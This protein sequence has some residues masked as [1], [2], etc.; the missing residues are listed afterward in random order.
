MIQPKPDPRVDAL[1][2]AHLR[3]V[4][5]IVCRYRD[6]PVEYDELIASGNLGLVI[7]ARKFDAT[8]GV[9]FP[10]YATYFVVR[11]VLVAVIRE[12]CPWHTATSGG[13]KSN[14]FFK[15]RAI[16]RQQPREKWASCVATALDLPE[17]AA[18]RLL[19]DFTV[20]FAA[21]WDF[22]RQEDEGAEDPEDAARNVEVASW[23]ARAMTCLT[24]QES[25]VIAWRYF[26]KRELTFEQIGASLGVSRQRAEQ[27]ERRAL[28]M[29]REAAKK[30]G[31]DWP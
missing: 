7:A 19:R 17:A 1:V 14:R 10:T 2:R 9:K 5:S 30:E 21:G 22:D 12:L 15:I 28:R 18:E 16:M 3:L 29:L 27:I 6:Y 20:V 25:R 8:R 13:W 24:S 31:V 11:E 4:P 23:I 26:D